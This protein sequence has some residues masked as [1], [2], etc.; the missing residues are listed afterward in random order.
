MVKPKQALS[1]SSKE[2]T[3][4]M[5]ELGDRRA[6]AERILIVAVFTGDGRADFKDVVRIKN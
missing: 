2:F 4:F 3:S 1:Y 6:V 5:K